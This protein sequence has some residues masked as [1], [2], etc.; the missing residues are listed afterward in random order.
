MELFSRNGQL[1]FADGTR[2]RVKGQNWFG[3]DCAD[4]CFSGL[5]AKPWTF[6]LDALHKDGYNL[7]RVPIA[8]DVI[9]G[10]NRLHPTTVNYSL[11][12][13]LNGLTSGQV[14][15]KVVDR[16][17]QLGITVVFDNQKLYSSASVA[18][19]WYD[20][21]T[22]EAT[23]INALKSLAARYKGRD[24]VVGIDCKNEPW[25][26]TVT[27]G[28]GNKSTDFDL[29]CA[30]LGDA[31]H[32]VNPKLLIFVEG[33]PWGPN[34]SHWGCWGGNLEWVKTKP[35]VLQAKDKVVY[36][37]H[38]YPPGVAKTLTSESDW[39]QRFGFIKDLKGAALVIGEH[40]S[41]SS[42]GPDRDWEDRFGAW[43]V[44]KDI[45]AL[46]WCVNGNCADTNGY[47]VDW[48]TVDP[49]KQK[50]NAT[51]CPNP[52]AWAAGTRLTSAA[53]PAPKPMPQAPAQ[54]VVPARK[55]SLP[56]STNMGG[57]F[58]LVS[59]DNAF[60]KPD[61]SRF[62]LKGTSWFGLETPDQSLQGLWQVSIEHVLDFLAA[63][64]FNFLRVPFS[65]QLVVTGLD[66]AH[67]TNL[68]S[69]ANPALAGKSSGAQLDRLFSLCAA[70][71][72]AIMLD[73]HRH[74]NTQQSPLWYT[75]QY[76][77]SRVIE[78]WQ[79]VLARYKDQPNFLAVDNFNEPQNSA[80]W[81]DDP[82]TGWKG[83]AER[84]G[85]SILR[86]A[87]HLV[88]GVQGVGGNGPDNQ[89]GWWG[90]NIWKNATNPLK[91]SNPQKLFFLPH[92]YGPSVFAQPYFSTSTFPGN[93]PAIW[94]SQWGSIDGPAIALGEWGGW[95]VGN[96]L[97][98]QNALVDYLVANKRTDSFYWCCCPTSGDTGGLL[99]NDWS[100]PVQWKLDMLKR[101]C[102]APSKLTFGTSTP[103]PAPTP[104]PTPTP[105]PPPAPTPSPTP[106]P[107]PT[108]A[109]TPVAPTAAS[110][111]GVTISASMQS[112][113]KS[114]A[115]N[116]YQYSLTLKN[117][118]AAPLHN[119]YVASSNTNV[120]RF[121]NCEYALTN[122]G[123]R[124]FSF[125]DWATENLLGPGQQITL[126]VVVTKG[127]SAFSINKVIV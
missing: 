38:A 101:L 111:L 110:K 41:K 88:I 105:T 30:R 61:G 106:T 109:P 10:L 1:E 71:G 17:A 123:Q 57:R 55:E 24:N 29:W 26:P 126:G 121:W 82:T 92:V 13:D 89:S 87:P 93:M 50:L 18:P 116:L 95:G 35:V 64:G 34:K 107:T 79:T 44:K 69:S 20:S 46:Y 112:Q 74:V 49:Y 120:V 70:R 102:P 8:I 14:L 104:S 77:E 59:H 72:I 65:A 9:E 43:L 51:I 53:P 98:W 28:T 113:Y 115:D 6:F 22:G 68:N 62:S 23:V 90:G 11:N 67:P 60:W 32:S 19:L 12:P 54:S 122:T 63:N 48:Q 21:N 100:T 52:T 39:Q 40:G 99:E 114:G 33:L 16:C 124:V 103:P 47:F 108:P 5:W 3:F 27:W 91:L 78:V 76:P 75:D 97:V 119:I 86:A 66:T 73:L 31:L 118:T 83:A 125:P 2:F 58:E 42:P 94:D 45:D 117:T 37:P 7:L 81:D 4:N 96:D 127:Q 56:P 84:I 36:A 15:D 25:D 80:T 85:N